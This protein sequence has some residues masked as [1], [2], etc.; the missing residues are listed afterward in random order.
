MS[1]DRQYKQSEEVRSRILDAARRIVSEE[2]VGALTIRRITKEI[3]YSAGIVYHYFENKEQILSCVLQKGYKR[4]LGSI[5]PVS[6]D[7]APDEAIRIS[8]T[9]FAGSVLK[10]PEEYRAIMLDSSPAVLAFTSVLN[11]EIREDKP[12]L[13]VL[14][15]TIEAGISNGMF[16]PCDARITA[17]AIWSAVFGLLVRLIIEKESSPKK[18]T[19]LIQRQIELIINGLK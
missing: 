16:A 19:E 9:N 11:D 3:D 7:L 10:H 14:I 1:R 2:G 15:A 13:T 8:I 17:Q 18:Q 5:R 4:I 6:E 12:A